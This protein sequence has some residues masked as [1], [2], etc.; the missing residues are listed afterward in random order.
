MVWICP[1]PGCF[2]DLGCSCYFSYHNGRIPDKKQ[3][4]E[5]DFCWFSLRACSSTGGKHGGGNLRL[6]AHI[7]AEK[8]MPVSI[9]LHFLILFSLEPQSIG[10]C[11]PI[12]GA[13]PP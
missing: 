2:L 5:G 9:W 3:L 1:C 10:W 11:C 12:Q 13:S 4:K 7:W 8:G 6:L